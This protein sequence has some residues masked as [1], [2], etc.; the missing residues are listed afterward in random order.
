MDQ[1]G[2][3]PP[4]DKSAV[5]LF[6]A[7]LSVVV[8]LVLGIACANVANLLLAQSAS[9][10]RE[11]AVRI[12]LGATRRQLLRADAGGELAARPSGRTIRHALDPLGD[13][14]TFRI[15]YSRAGAA[16][17][18]RQHRLARPAVHL[19]P[20]RGNRPAVRVRTRMDRFASYSGQ[21]AERRGCFRPSRP[22][23]E[24]AQCSRGGADCHVAGSALRHRTVSAQPASGP[25]ASTSASA[26]A[27]F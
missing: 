18:N 16:G 14:S 17:Y 11:M 1:A 4:R 2:S 12:A 21:R 27:M 23:P 20:Q 15:S 19:C 9:R 5:L 3:L 26:R 6:I 24:L 10:Q 22:P 7:A 25:S 13:I 8:L